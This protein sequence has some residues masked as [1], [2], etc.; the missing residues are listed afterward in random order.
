MASP[1][2]MLRTIGG[3][4]RSA[5]A[6]G[7]VTLLA[8]TP[9]AVAFADADRPLTNP[10][11]V[12][13]EGRGV[14]PAS[15]SR[16]AHSLILEG[17]REAGGPGQQIPHPHVHI[18]PN[19]CRWVPRRRVLYKTRGGG[20]GYTSSAISEFSGWVG[21]YRRGAWSPPPLRLRAR[22]D[23]VTH[24]R[25]SYVLSVPFKPLRAS[26]QKVY[27]ICIHRRAKRAAKKIGYL[28]SEAAQT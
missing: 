22:L 15:F 21:A 27:G 26:S 23:L 6:V 18:F 8:S 17:V 28:G 13:F 1:I 10:R 19:S 16:N 24:T 7:L 4:A 25:Q 3:G 9:G 12:T 20:T 5:A 14:G 2:D 11:Q